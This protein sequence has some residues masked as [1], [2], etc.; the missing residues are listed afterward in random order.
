MTWVPLRVGECDESPFV[1]FRKWF[2]EAATVMREREAIAL[3]T[4]DGAGHPSVRMVLLRHVGETTVRWFTN[5]HSRKGSELEANPFAAL[6]WY[7]E[8]LGRQVRIEG[9]VTRASAEVSD[10]YFA[11]RPRGHQIG[12]HASDQSTEIESREALAARV[13]ESSRRFPGEVS[14]PEH[15]GGY[16]LTPVSF[17]FWQHREDRLH[18]R[19]VYRPTGSGWA[20]VRLSP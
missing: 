13:D 4:A 9:P 8:P 16:E 6:L 7:C 20:R 17:E 18:D 1:Q 14:R 19:V 10:R 2:D 12:A 3:A 5:Y 15:W 11:S